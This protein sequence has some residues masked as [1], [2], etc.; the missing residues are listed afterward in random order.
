MKNRMWWAGLWGMPAR[1]RWA[2]DV[3]GLRLTG[4]CAAVMAGLMLGAAA[5]AEIS[6]VE[7]GAGLQKLAGDFS[8]TEGP[9]VDAEGNVFFT[10]QP[11]NRIL[12]WSA[13]GGVTTFLEP[14]G[15]SNGLCFAADGVL[16]ACADERNELWAIRPDGTHTVLAGGHE[17][18]RLNGPNDV[19]AHPDGSL[20]FTDPFYRRRWWT[21][22]EQPQDGQHVY[23]LAPDRRT[24]TRVA[25]DLTQPNG[26]TGT[27]D[28][29]TLYVADLGVQRTYAYAIRPDG[30]LA[31][32]RLVCGEG[33]DGMTLDEEGRLYL[34]GRGVMIYE[35]S[36]R[37]VQRIEVPE[38]WCANVCFGGPD[39]RTLFITAS[40]GLYAI[41][42]K[43][44]GALP[45]K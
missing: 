41:R 24:L 31:D 37:L 21:H 25:A 43:T 38:S 14:A 34:T 29:K 40:R 17:G 10:D 2:R 4:R 45:A 19:W 35:P 42:L 1:T 36:G 32:R 26:I 13:G 6:L 30:T 12:K 15:R 16:I 8:F 27:P 20:Y 5:A 9:T 3:Y 28:G 33:S 22:T 39:R 11:N 7:D 18:R 23:R 44:R